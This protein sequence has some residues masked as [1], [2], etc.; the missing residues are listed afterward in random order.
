MEGLLRQ[1]AEKE[2][3][4]AFAAPTRA[5]W[6]NDLASGM[7]AAVNWLDRVDVNSTEVGVLAESLVQARRDSSLRQHA[8]AEL[9]ALRTDLSRAI[10]NQGG[11][12]AAVGAR[13]MATLLLAMLDGL[14]LHRMVDPDLG[15]RPASRSIRALLEDDLNKETVS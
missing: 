13:G 4:Q 12:P 6:R 9:E 1:A 15:L 14:L 3:T 10:E 11:R 8:A 2:L 7:R 5:A